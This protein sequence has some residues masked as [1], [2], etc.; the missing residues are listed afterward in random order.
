M[1]KL[2]ALLFLPSIAL[3]SGYFGSGGGGGGSIGGAMT[4][5][6]QYSVLFVDPDGVIAQ[7]NT[8]LNFNNSTNTLTLGLPPIV[9][10]FSSAGIV[11][12]DSS[13]LFSSSLLVNADVSASA[14]IAYS[15]LN[16][17]GSI[18]G[19]D[20]T[21][22]TIM[23]ADVNA[24]A[25]IAYSKLNLTGG[26]V[27]ADV[28]ASAAIAYSKL[29]LAGSILGSDITD[30]TIMN[31]D[32]NASAAIARTKLASGTNYRILANDSSGVMSENAAL[33]AG[34][35][36]YPDANGQLTGEAA[37]TYAAASDKITVPNIDFSGTIK[38]IGGASVISNPG[39]GGSS[40]NFGQIALAFPV[41]DAAVVIGNGAVGESQGCVSVGFEAICS[42]G[43][44]SSGGIAIGSSANNGGDGGIAIGPA[45]STA[46]AA[47]SIAIGNGSTVTGDQNI[48][49][50]ASSVAMSGDATAVGFGANSNLSGVAI[51]S[52]ATANQSISLGQEASSSANQF[53]AGSGDIPINDVFFGKGSTNI[54]A[55]NVTINGTG[56]SGSNN[57][58]GNLTLAAGRSTGS[59]APASVKIQTTT[60]AGSSSTAQTLTD[61]ATFGSTQITLAR[62]SIAPVGTRG[63]PTSVTAAGGVSAPTSA[64]QVS[65]VQGNSAGETDITANPQIAAGTY[66]GQ[67]LVVVCRSDANTIKFEDGTGL[68]MQGP[69]VCGADSVISWLWDG[70]NWLET[71][72]RN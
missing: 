22:G 56:G 59:G 19:S 68:S 2:L 15:K 54:S 10:S 13:G 9:S 36:V 18:L 55:T 29:N 58:A 57:V 70:T 45:A 21:D 61:I 26:I 27:N 53:V 38:G 16:L 37:F 4:G 47:N 24:S 41:G 48:A 46:A 12:N 11:H 66:V 6:T 64:R 23:N 71:S 67:E 35:V 34:R 65:F 31:A 5:G 33:T 39:A 72:R 25:A 32:V 1:K 3:A 20:I 50:G 69:F 17:A 42:Y 63:S 49:V 28:N 8:N 44:G 62:P 14:A 52:G 51:G 40:E 7:D 30:G 60:V 43:A